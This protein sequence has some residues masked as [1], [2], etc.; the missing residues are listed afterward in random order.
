MDPLSHA[1]PTGNPMQAAQLFNS[2]SPVDPVS[3]LPVSF[4]NT[5]PPKESFE[6]AYLTS[7]PLIR[8][9]KVEGHGVHAVPI[10]KLDI[11]AEK[12]LLLDC[13][14]ES[15]KSVRIRCEVA[16]SSSLQ[17]VVTLGCR[18]LHY[19]GHGFTGCLAF[20]DG[21][22]EMHELD[23]CALS[24]LV[25]GS[26]LKFV[27]VSACRSQDA[28]NAFI[29]M[30]VPHVVAV[31]WDSNVSDAASRIFFEAFYL[32]VLHGHT[33]KAAFERGKTACE[34]AP[35]SKGMA[36]PAEAE[37][38]VL[39]PKGAN[40]DEAIF[41]DISDGPWKDMTPPVP[42]HRIPAIP[43]HFV[44]RCV[45]TQAFFS[46]LCDHRLVT[47]LGARG[48]GKTALAIRVAQ[49]ACER[50]RGLGWDG[51]GFVSFGSPRGAKAKSLGELISKSL[52]PKLF[53]PCQSNSDFFDQ[54]DE[55]RLLLVLDGAEKLDRYTDDHH[56]LNLSVFLSNLL[57]S[58]KHV[59]VLITSTK[60]VKNVEHASEKVLTIQRL[61]PNDAALLFYLRSPRQLGPGEIG[62][63]SD[64]QRVIS[65]RGLL[66][67]LE[68]HE[69]LNYLDGNPKRICDAV[70]HLE[71]TPLNNLLSNLREARKESFTK[72]VESWDV[73]KIWQGMTSED[74][75]LLSTLETHLNGYFVKQTRCTARPLSQTD[76]QFLCKK[77][78]SFESAMNPSV[79]S[80]NSQ[81]DGGSY[82]P[83]RISYRA[84]S[85]F[86]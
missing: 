84:F 54:I 8:R 6:L 19:S 26:N 52:E 29:T 49:Y 75:I 22:G 17:K 34:H 27:F 71:N 63:K 46:K 50:A 56:P 23:V 2:S 77:C 25:K 45:E 40:H 64:G 21:K 37:K 7:S 15:N 65:R 78:E 4:P 24:N 16:T 43:E 80:R 72:T 18:A 57:S 35:E 86:W 53:Q 10:D 81:T 13:L 70:G 51:I 59:R 3:A 85:K 11:Q 62:M 68:K 42:V 12:R 73:S 28:A 66:K 61:P 60:S 38:F 48:V 67:L 5:V 79:R 36:S 83:T 33:V 47:M 55:K 1:L 76:L 58:C 14:K 69:V 39:L 82:T 20:E 32:S 9:I 31:C 44:G 41:E 30:K 74:T